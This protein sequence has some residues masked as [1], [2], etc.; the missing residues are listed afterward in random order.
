MK[1]AVVNLCAKSDVCTSVWSIAGGG[2]RHHL[3]GGTVFSRLRCNVG[4]RADAGTIEFPTGRCV[5]Y[6]KKAGCRTRVTKLRTILLLMSCRFTVRKH[7]DDMRATGATEVNT[8]LVTTTQEKNKK[9]NDT[10]SAPKNPLFV[11]K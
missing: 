4:A 8:R 2:V 10:S 6:L 1:S 3:L 9:N 5:W 7:E 11:S